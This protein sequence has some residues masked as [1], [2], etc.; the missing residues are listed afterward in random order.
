ME[1]HDG[2]QIQLFLFKLRLLLPELHDRLEAIAVNGAKTKISTRLE[3]IS[4]ATANGQ[5]VVLQ[6]RRDSADEFKF[7]PPRCESSV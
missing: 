5:S 6:T 1:V 2:E 7:R 4:A 3:K